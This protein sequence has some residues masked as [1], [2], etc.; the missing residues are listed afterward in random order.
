MRIYLFRTQAIR[1]Q[2][3][4]DTQHAGAHDF[5]EN[6]I[7]RMIEH[8]RVYAFKFQ[9]ANKETVQYWQDIGTL[10]AYWK[11]NM[12]LVPVDPQF[13]LYDQDLPI[14]TDQGQF[15]PATFIFAQD[16]D[17]GRMGTPLDSIV[18]GGCIVS[19]AHVQ[20]SVLLPYV[21]VLDHAMSTN[22]S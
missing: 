15:S 16:Y 11:A 14:R 17:G 4:A 8:G 22:Q 3:L 13:N 2:L 19:W 9:D 18:C 10:D 1:E 6:I 7:P 5:D 21:R 20:N 12:D